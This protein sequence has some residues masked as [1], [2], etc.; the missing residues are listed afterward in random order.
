MHDLFFSWR[1]YTKKHQDQ[2]TF[3]DLLNLLNK[4]N[5]KTINDF[6]FLTLFI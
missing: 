3:K 4:P 5:I 1:V 2:L 6:E